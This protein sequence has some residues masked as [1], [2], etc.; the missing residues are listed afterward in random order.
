MRGSDQ[1]PSIVP[2][3]THQD[4]YLVLDEFRGFGQAWRETDVHDTDLETL[5]EDLL[6]GQYRRGLV[7]RCLRCGGRNAAPPLFGTQERFDI[8]GA[9]LRRPLQEPE[10]GQQMTTAA[11]LAP[12]LWRGLCVAKGK[13]RRGLTDRASLGTIL[14][15]AFRLGAHSHQLCG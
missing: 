5:I 6:D 7:A 12:R 9:G 13:T 11:N 1:S 2:R 15:L 14:A 10:I 3:D 8:L 4:V